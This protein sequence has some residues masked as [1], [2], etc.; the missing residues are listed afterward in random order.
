MTSGGFRQIKVDCRASAGDHAE[1]RSTAQNGNDGEN[2][3]ETTYFTPESS[4]I[5]G[6]GNAPPLMTG[7]NPRMAEIRDTIAKVSGTDVT[8]LIRG[9][10]GV[11]KE[12]AARMIYEH[13]RRRQKPFIK[14]NCAAI[15]HDLL[16]SELFGYEAGSIHGS[17]SQQTGKI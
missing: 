17:Y 8:I 2:T 1:L 11:G 6:N 16:E 3:A 12:V 14:V 7:G 9:E 13:S 4:A 10:S 15:P 5:A